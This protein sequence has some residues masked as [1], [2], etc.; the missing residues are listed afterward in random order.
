MASFRVAAQNL[1]GPLEKQ[2]W[3]TILAVVH[4]ALARLET[5]CISRSF[6]AAGNAHDAFAVVGQVLYERRGTTPSSLTPMLTKR[7]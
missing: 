3:H 4:E 2:N 5:R 7:C 6:I 1:S